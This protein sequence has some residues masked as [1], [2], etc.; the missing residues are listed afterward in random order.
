M[1]R[2]RRGGAP[3]PIP[4][5]RLR[6]IAGVESCDLWTPCSDVFLSLFPLPP[7]GLRRGG[8][9]F[10]VILLP[11]ERKNPYEEEEEVKVLF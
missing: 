4:P 5:R 8:G 9:T 6:S 7:F 2:R 1:E 10:F 3:H 11:R